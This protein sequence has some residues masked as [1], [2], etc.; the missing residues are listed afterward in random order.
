LFCFFLNNFHSSISPTGLLLLRMADPENET[1]ALAA[2]SYKQVRPFQ[3]QNLP[4]DA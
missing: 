2:F 3:Q 4:E 1:P